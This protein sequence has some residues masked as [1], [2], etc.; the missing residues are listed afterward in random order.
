MSKMFVDLVEL[1]WTYRADVHVASHLHCYAFVEKLDA[2]EWRVSASYGRLAAG[3]A[4]S[5]E[6]GKERVQRVISLLAAVSKLEGRS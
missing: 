5:L 2:W 3:A 4:S 1:D 6:E